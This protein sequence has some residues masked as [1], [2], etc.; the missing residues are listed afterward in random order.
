MTHLDSRSMRVSMTVNTLVTMLLFKRA[1]V[2]LVVPA[3]KSSKSHKICFNNG[4]EMSVCVNL[5]I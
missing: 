5:L 3:A 1:W 2:Y 4:F